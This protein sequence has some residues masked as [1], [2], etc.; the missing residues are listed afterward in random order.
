M[1]RGTWQRGGNSNLKE[2]HIQSKWAA[3]DDSID[4]TTPNHQN[5]EFEKSPAGV[6]TGS[7]KMELRKPA[8]NKTTT[9][10]LHRQHTTSNHH[11]GIMQQA[12]AAERSALLTTL[13][14][15]Y[16]FFF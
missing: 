12:A 5:L 4:N 15:T 13:F 3:H 14:I 8:S 1:R 6:N 11:I 16:P 7:H 2:H 10:V 9:V